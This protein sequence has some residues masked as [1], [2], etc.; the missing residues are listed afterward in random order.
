MFQNIIST[1]ECFH[2]E[3]PNVKIYKLDYDY[4]KAAFDTGQQR[5]L[6]HITKETASDLGCATEK[7]SPKQMISLPQRFEW[8]SFQ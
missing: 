2:S 7:C 4:H 5:V 6:E 3:A 8:Q 1:I